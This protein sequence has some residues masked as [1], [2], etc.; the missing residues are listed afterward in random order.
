M[1]EIRDYEKDIEG[2]MLLMKLWEAEEAA[3]DRDRRLSTWGEER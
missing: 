3:K 1:L 2:K